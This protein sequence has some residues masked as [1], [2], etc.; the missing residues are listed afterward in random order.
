MRRRRFKERVSRIRPLIYDRLDLGNEAREELVG[1]TDRIRNSN[2]R[3]A[4]SL[5]DDDPMIKASHFLERSIQL[6]EN[7]QRKE[8]IVSSMSA[9]QNTKYK[10]DWENEKEKC[11]RMLSIGKSMAENEMKKRLG[12][13]TSQG[14][15]PDRKAL[16]FFSYNSADRRSKHSSRDT[17]APLE[18]G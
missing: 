16:A 14:T 1:I 18:T 6:L 13:A 5:N 17:K 12:M 4:Y 7:Y 15:V 11:R 2:G 9:E 8:A 3:G 10:Q